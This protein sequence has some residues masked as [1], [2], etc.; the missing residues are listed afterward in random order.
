M[1]HPNSSVPSGVLTTAAARRVGARLSPRV[2]T[3]RASAASHGRIGW[4]PQEN[5]RS[6][7]GPAVDAFA[8]WLLSL[9]HTLF[10]PGFCPGDWV[11]ATSAAGA[12]IALSPV[13]GAV[14]V[15]VMRKFTGNRY[16]AV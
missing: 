9:A 5:D 16:D 12:L 11:W 7:E 4:T 2:A 13:L 14:V 3:R 10:N 1:P 15:A 8:S 6:Q